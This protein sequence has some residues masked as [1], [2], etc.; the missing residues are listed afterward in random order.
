MP[1]GPESDVTPK[2]MRPP[3]KK[4]SLTGGFA[5]GTLTAAGRL[6]QAVYCRES[7]DTPS[8]NAFCC[9]A[10]GVRLSDLAIFATGVF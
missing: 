9:V 1:V 3:V 10:P 6:R 2:A 4:A 5:Y 8:V 7:R